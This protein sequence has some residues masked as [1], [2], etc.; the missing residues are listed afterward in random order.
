VKVALGIMLLGLSCATTFGQSAAD[1]VAASQ[2]VGQAVRL[3]NDD[4]YR[5]MEGM[6]GN[7][8]YDTFNF[9]VV[10]QRGKE[11]TLMYQL[12]EKYTFFTA[13]CDTGCGSNMM[14][15]EGRWA[16]ATLERKNKNAFWLY[17]KPAES[18]HKWTYWN[19]TSLSVLGSN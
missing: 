11:I 10:S 1:D 15:P 4:A 19:V 5:T 6:I 7:K 14:P 13:D 8:K 9:Y 3:G 18:K 17:T 12:N 2:R 16:Y